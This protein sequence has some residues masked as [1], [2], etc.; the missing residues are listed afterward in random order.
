MIC[1]DA[2]ASEARRVGKAAMSVPDHCRPAF[3][4]MVGTLSLCRTPTKIYPPAHTS[5]T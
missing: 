4:K 1:D 5:S 3:R 2:A